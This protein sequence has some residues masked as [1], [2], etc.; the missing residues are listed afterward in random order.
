MYLQALFMAATLLATLPQSAQAERDNRRGEER[1]RDRRPE[2]EEPRREMSLDQAV[3]MVQ[4]RYNARVV[5]AETRRQN[6]RTV[7]RLKLLN[8]DGK[9][10]TVTVDAATGTVK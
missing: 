4:K 10:W 8:K 7:Y 9:V 1:E 3:K 2:K 6:D 5:S